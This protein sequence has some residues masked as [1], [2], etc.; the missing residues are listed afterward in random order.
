M[1]DTSEAGIRRTAL[2]LICAGLDEAEAAVSQLLLDLTE[3]MDE[4]DPRKPHNDP[5]GCGRLQ[6]CLHDAIQRV[7]WVRTAIDMAACQVTQVLRQK[8]R[9]QTIT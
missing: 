2:D 4:L 9:L 8:P 3:Q 6:V 5:V 7:E 1:V